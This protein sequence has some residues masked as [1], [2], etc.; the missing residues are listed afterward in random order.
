MITV[1]DIG[2]KVVY[3]AALKQVKKNL[4]KI[5]RLF[6]NKITKEE[7]E[8][9]EVLAVNNTE[10]ENLD[11]L[12]YFPNLLSLGMDYVI[13]INNINGVQNCPNLEEFDLCNCDVKSLDGIVYCKNLTCFCYDFSEEYQQYGK[14]DFGFLKNLPELK[15]IILERN[16]L[17]DVSIFANLHKVTTLILTRNP[18]TNIAPL[19]ELKSLECL[20]VDYCKLTSLDGLGEFK[21]LKE[22]GAAGNLFT[23]EQMSEYKQRYPQIE[24]FFED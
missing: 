21:S 18:I 3:K 14:S 2:N 13:G 15:V 12:K 17:E 16:K 1:Q 20:D 23:E 5:K 4:P 19:K 10:I 11:F 22:L 9:I 7:A 24:I 8:K 6:K